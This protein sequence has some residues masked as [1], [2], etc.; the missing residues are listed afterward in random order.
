MN[1]HINLLQ[2]EVSIHYLLI[3]L[4]RLDSFRV[5]LPVWCHTIWIS[6]SKILFR[7]SFNRQQCSY[8]RTRGHKVQKPS[9]DCRYA[10]KVRSRGV[11]VQFCGCLPAEKSS[12]RKKKNFTCHSDPI[13]AVQWIFSIG[14]PGRVIKLARTVHSVATVRPSVRSG[15]T[16]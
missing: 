13:V 2:N 11:T 8:H 15:C 4:R 9:I 6:P 7:I 14:S 12:I 5:V 16:R 10:L 1:L 3:F